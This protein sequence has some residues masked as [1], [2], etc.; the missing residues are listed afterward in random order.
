MSTNEIIPIFLVLFTSGIIS[1]LIGGIIAHLV[2]YHRRKQAKSRK[3]S[4]GSINAFID[5]MKR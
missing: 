4:D 3:G 1:S 2:F 5:L